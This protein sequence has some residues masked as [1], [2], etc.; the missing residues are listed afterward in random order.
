MSLS[1]AKRETASRK[2][3]Q[4]R[5]ARIWRF[6]FLLVLALLALSVFANIYLGVT[7]RIRPVIIKV[8]HDKI[9]EVVDTSALEQPE[10][11][12][13]KTYITKWITDCRTVIAD[14]PVQKQMFDRCLAFVKPGSEAFETI[15]NYFDQ[16]NPT[17]RQ[18]KERVSIEVS[19]VV[20]EGTTSGYW[21]D[22]KE[23]RTEVGTG[24]EGANRYRGIV[25]IEHNYLTRQKDVY[26]NPFGLFIKEIDWS[27]RND[28]DF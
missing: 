18:R 15:K 7:S 13:V 24:N 21:I 25:V 11:L 16:N 5:N 22:W 10:E 17:L 3:E 27:K 1:K 6:S 26:A 9:V 4:V 14:R 8:D 2:N 19:G 12:I 20:R 23:N 28:L